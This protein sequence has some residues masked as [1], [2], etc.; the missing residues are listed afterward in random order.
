[1]RTLLIAGNWKMNPALAPKPSPGGSRE[2][3]RRPVDVVRV[4]VCPPAVFLSEVDAV[5][6]GSPDRLGGTEHAL[7]AGRGLHRRAFRRDAPR[8]R[9]HSCDPGP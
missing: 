6:E 8:C 7:G 4:V 5:L 9:L 1:M 2:G 3:G